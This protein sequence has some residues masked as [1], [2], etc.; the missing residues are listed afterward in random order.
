M[1]L[2][3]LIETK[4]VKRVKKE[5]RFTLKNN[6]FLT[7]IATIGSGK[8]QMYNYLWRH[9]QMNPD[10]YAL[11]CMKGFNSRYSRISHI[12]KNM[13]KALSPGITP[14][15]C[16]ED[17][18]TLLEQCLQNANK[19]GKKVILM[20]DEAQDLNDQ[21]FFDMK[22]IH[23][24]GSE[25]SDSLFSIVLFGKNSVKWDKIFT[26]Q[27][28]G[29]RIQRTHMDIISPD[30]AVEIANK[31]FGIKFQNEKA[32]ERW[33][34][35][36]PETRTPLNVKHLINMLKKA[37]PEFDGIIGEEFLAE[38][39]GTDKKILLKNN[40]I[41]QAMIAQKVQDENPEIKS[42]KKRVS[43]FLN[44]KKTTQKINEA[45]NEATYSLIQEKIETGSVQ[46]KKAIS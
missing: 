11:Y 20:I 31:R 8:T 10:K 13:I 30:E 42:A 16:T 9:W 15:Q 25:Y 38:Y 45:M 21:T 12:M 43:D 4:N 46:E 22:K 26:N 40:G 17:K 14:P 2:P 34:T 7:V 23:E 41:T 27:E 6:G 3:I 32:K 28:L 44:N 1:D 37:V 36:L 39:F 5:I 24:L 29:C 33:L 19:L 18:Y 35:Y